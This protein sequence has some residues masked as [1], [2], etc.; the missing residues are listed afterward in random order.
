[1]ANHTKGT[2]LAGSTAIEK[3]DKVQ[4][5]ILDTQM[6]PES[7]KA[8]TAL[9]TAKIPK[10]DIQKHPGKGGK[11]F[12]YVSH[13]RATETMHNALGM[14]WEW[15]ILD[16]QL[17][18]DKSAVARGQM[19]LHYRDIEGNARTRTITEVGGFEDLTGKFPMCNIILG[20]SSRALLRC[21]LRAFGYGRELY[22][23]DESTPDEKAAWNILVKYATLKKVPKE[24]LKKALK[25]AGFTAETLVDRFEEAYALVQ[26][27][28]TPD[29][30]EPEL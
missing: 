13:I 20:A 22:P 11:V 15:Q 10:E 4:I 9:R 25:E 26:K 21:M 16:Y 30:T 28:A 27:L 18:P 3:V 24:V 23:E 7:L 8:I 17:L 2:G 19:T 5:E 6:S 12:S 14:N 29:T 1:M